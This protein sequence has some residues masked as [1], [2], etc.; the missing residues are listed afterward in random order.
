M[1][2]E[3]FEVIRW[4][5]ELLLKEFF[6]VI[7]EYISNNTNNT[8]PHSTPILPHKNKVVV[9]FFFKLNTLCYIKKKLPTIY[10]VSASIL[11][12]R[13]LNIGS[14]EGRILR[15]CY[16]YQM[17]ECHLPKTSFTHFNC[18][19]VEPTC[20]QLQEHFYCNYDRHG[21]LMKK[22]KKKRIKKKSILLPY[23]IF[24]QNVLSS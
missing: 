13:L 23:R 3:A 11:C 8:D 4:D 14:K 16:I 6:I 20:L 19:L 5:E 18:L 7:T 10:L 12:L 24:L 21:Y 1:V 9:F 2:E 17:A 22:K 15:D